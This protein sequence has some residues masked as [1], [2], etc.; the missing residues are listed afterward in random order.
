MNRTHPWGLLEPYAAMSGTYGSEGAAA[1]QCA[2]ATRQAGAH[3]R[4]RSEELL[5]TALRRASL[6]ARQRFVTWLLTHH[7]TADPI[8]RRR[9]ERNDAPVRHDSTHLIES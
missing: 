3:P 8:T 1:Q 2:A 7:R 6:E 4:P 5:D 9:N